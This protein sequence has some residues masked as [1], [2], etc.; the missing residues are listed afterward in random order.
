VPKLQED[1]RLHWQVQDWRKWTE[2]VASVPHVRRINLG[3]QAWR[4]T[5]RRAGEV[6]N[7]PIYTHPE[8]QDDWAILPEGVDEVQITYSARVLERGL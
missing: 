3:K 7:I 1:M 6:L 8:T 5:F 2:D 4:Y